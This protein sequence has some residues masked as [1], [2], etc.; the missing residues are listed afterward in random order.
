[1]KLASLKSSHSVSAFTTG[2]PRRAV[3]LRT[4]AGFVQ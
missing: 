4:D 1:M 2:D 3:S